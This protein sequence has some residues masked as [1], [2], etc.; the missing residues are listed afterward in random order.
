[1]AFY[2]RNELCPCGSGKKYKNCCIH[3]EVEYKEI[4][5]I[6]EASQKVKITEPI[7]VSHKP[8]KGIRELCLAQLEQICMVLRKEH[9]KDHIIRL[10]SND[11]VELTSDPE[12]KYVTVMKEI[13]EAQGKSDQQII[14]RMS[15]WVQT[16]RNGETLNSL[17]KIIV[18]QLMESNLDKYILLSEM[19][20]MDYGEML[21]INELCYNLIKEG[22]PKNRFIDS[23][24][25]YVGTGN[26]LNNWEIHYHPQLLV[27]NNAPEP[28][29]LEHDIFIEWVALDEFEHEYENFVHKL[30]AL[31]EDSKKSLVT[32]LYQENKLAD[33]PGNLVSYNGIAS[34][35]TGILEQEFRLLISYHQGLKFT[36]RMMW[37]EICDYLKV[38]DL[39]VIVDCI[40][41][42]YDKMMEIYPMRNKIAHGEPILHK[43]FLLVK[44]LAMES[45]LLEFI[46]WAKVEIEDSNEILNNKKAFSS[47]TETRSTFLV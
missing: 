7:L 31:S 44:N 30:H 4:K 17:E 46:S 26:K 6:R 38:H 14:F 21:V 42:I 12:D 39:P 24:T 36:K 22:L 2:G 25:V 19:E 11:L 47:A 32:A 35:Y 33:T 15:E 8:E 10:N 5:T 27:F 40:P 3:K 16:A 20:T 34:Y 29:E 23:I 1:M 9:K 43:D 41:D 37:K 45:Q 18:R 28:D 13:F